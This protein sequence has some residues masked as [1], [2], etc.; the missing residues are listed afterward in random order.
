[1][2]LY[3]N[4]HLSVPLLGV[5]S[6][7]DGFNGNYMGTVS[8]TMSGW[9]CQRWDWQTP[10]KH[11][12]GDK[13]DNFLEEKFPENYCRAPLDDES[14]SPWCYTTSLKHRW[15]PCDVCFCQPCGKSFFFRCTG[16]TVVQ[17]Q[18]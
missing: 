15:Q 5:G 17:R 11:T 7:S 2:F 13:P 4:V 1:M 10:Q 3:N 16:H 8:K 18:I 12:S 9:E 6:C 14:P